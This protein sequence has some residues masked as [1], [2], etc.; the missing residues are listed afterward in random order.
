ME[1]FEVNFDG[2]VGPTHNYGGLSFGNLSSSKHALSFSNPKEAAK[3]GLAKMKWLGDLGI[4]QGI[5][6]PHE[7]PDIA[8]LKK[9]GFSGND[10]Q[11]L[12]SAQ[13]QAPAILMACFTASSMWTANAATVSPSADT[14]DHKVH[15]TPANLYGNFHRSIEAEGTSKILRTIFHDEDYFVHHAPL[16]GGSIFSD[17]GAANHTRFSQ[18]HHNPGIEFFVYGRFLEAPPNRLPQK[19]PSRQTLEASTAISRLH[20]LNPEKV[21]FAQQNPD[22]IDAGVFHNDVISVGNQN[23]FFFHSSAFVETPHVIREIQQKF[24]PEEMELIEVMEAQIPIADA[25]QSYLFNSQLLTLPDRTTILVSPIEC[26]EN[27]VVKKYMDQLITGNSTIKTVHYFDLR[28]SMK[29]GGGPACLR[30]RVVLTEKELQKCHPGVL[31]NQ[32]LYERLTLWVEKHYRDRLHPDDLADPLLLEEIRRALD[33]LTQI[34]QLGSIYTFQ[35][36]KK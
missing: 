24:H 33:D 23:I 1:A 8:T 10:M 34:L 36:E 28:Q 29:N 18:G 17:E 16:P 32:H 2:L 12:Q 27:P 31:L 26:Q 14:A 20:R 11:I 13:Q 6:P 5:L 35:Q 19:F 7:R 4:R 22:A 15:F 9:L 21:V 3:Q 25:V 30:L